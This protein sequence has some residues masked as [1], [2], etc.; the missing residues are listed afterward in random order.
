MPIQ[1]L[2]LTIYYLRSSLSLCVFCLSP[3]VVCRHII[4]HVPIPSSCDSCSALRFPSGRSI[5]NTRIYTC[6]E[7]SLININVRAHLQSVIC[8]YARV[9]SASLFKPPRRTVSSDIVASVRHQSISG[10]H[11]FCVAVWHAGLTAGLPRFCRARMLTFPICKIKPPAKTG[12]FST[13]DFRKKTIS[14]HGLI[15]AR[16]KSLAA[17]QC[18]RLL[19]TTVY[20]SFQVDREGSCAR[21]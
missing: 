14:S 20:T 16:C 10:Y 4:L 17:P 5:L 19:S 7:L 13:P 8:E 21:A 18:L 12:N 11:V 6:C 3:R 15:F 1:H 2:R 9:V